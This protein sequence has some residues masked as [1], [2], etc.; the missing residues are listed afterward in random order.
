MARQEYGRTHQ[1]STLGISEVQYIAHVVLFSSLAKV[2]NPSDVES[3][4][5]WLPAEK[6]INVP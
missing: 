2:G 5:A 3:K 1:E 6:V 4:I